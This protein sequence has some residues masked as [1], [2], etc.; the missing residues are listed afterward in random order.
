MGDEPTNQGADNVKRADDEGFVPLSSSIELPW[1]K[2]SDIAFGPS[3]VGDINKRTIACVDR[4]LSTPN[5]VIHAD[6]FKQSADMIVDALVEG[7]HDP[8]PCDVFFFPIAYLYR[9]AICVFR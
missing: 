9:H 6:A 5:L 4:L 7:K 3:E 8:F 2:R 1:P